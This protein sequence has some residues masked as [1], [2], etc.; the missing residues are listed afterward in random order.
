[1]GVPA[2]PCRLALSMRLASTCSIKRG[3]TSTPGGPGGDYD[4]HTTV[5]ER[6]T[7]LGQGLVHQVADRQ[8]PA[9]D[10]QRPGL[11]AGHVEQAVHQPRETVSLHVDKAVKLV[12]IVLGQVVRPVEECRRSHF[13]GGERG[14]QVVGDGADEGTSQAVDLLEQFGMEYAFSQLSSFESDGEVVGQD[15]QRLRVHVP[16]HVPHDEQTYGTS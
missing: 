9:A 2:G 10:L 5:H 13:D 7:Q 4:V 1:M 6:R 14:A 16:G 12:G 8:G 15:R 11:D 3:S